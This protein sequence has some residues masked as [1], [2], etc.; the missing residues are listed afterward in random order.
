MHETVG[1]EFYIPS[2]VFEFLLEL[3]AAELENL[4]LGYEPNGL[5]GGHFN[6]SLA[7][8]YLIHV[9]LMNAHSL[10]SFCISV[11]TAPIVRFDTLLMF[12]C[13][14]EPDVKVIELGLFV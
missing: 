12:P 3:W 14:L 8:D 13:H 1:S 10:L 2:W 7:F 5:V 6:S 9:P 11:H 4:D